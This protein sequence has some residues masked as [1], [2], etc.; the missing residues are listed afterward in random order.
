MSTKLIALQQ[1]IKYLNLRIFDDK[2][3]NNIYDDVSKKVST[4]L[5]VPVYLAFHKT[6]EKKKSEIF[7]KL[8]LSSRSKDCIVSKL[9]K[10]AF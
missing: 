7:Q 9:T 4:Q 8:A 6:S 1:K 3:R 2:I 10:Y 5:S